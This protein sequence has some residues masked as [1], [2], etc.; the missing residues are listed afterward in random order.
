MKKQK[1]LLALKGMVKKTRD[2]TYFVASKTIDFIVEGLDRAKCA[3]IVTTRAD[4]ITVALSEAFGSSGI[5]VN[6]MGGYT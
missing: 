3:M 1:R 6:A 5:I 2:S 4:M